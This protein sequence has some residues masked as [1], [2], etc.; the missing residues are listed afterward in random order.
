ML[1]FTSLEAR[2]ET[3]VEATVETAHACGEMPLRGIVI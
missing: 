2:E 3:A 1:K